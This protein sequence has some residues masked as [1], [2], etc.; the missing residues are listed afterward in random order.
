MGLMTGCESTGTA[1]AGHDDDR[2][3]P[4]FGTSRG[5]L[6]DSKVLFLEALSRHDSAGSRVEKAVRWL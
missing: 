1:L 4:T 2:V 3:E 6:V 5:V